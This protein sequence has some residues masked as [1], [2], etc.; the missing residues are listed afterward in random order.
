LPL[1][2]GYCKGFEN[3]A[4][5]SLVVRSAPSQRH[6]TFREQSLITLSRPILFIVESDEKGLFHFQSSVTRMERA[7]R[8]LRFYN[9]HRLAERD[10]KFVSS[11]CSMRPPYRVPGELA[12]DKC[13]L[14]IPERCDAFL[15]PKSIKSRLIVH[16]SLA[17][18]A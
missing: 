1:A 15:Y 2:L 17:P 14:P 7:A 13:A 16:P 6:A 9:N 12:Y 11:H 10:Y 4:K 8:L 5:L 3:L 18:L